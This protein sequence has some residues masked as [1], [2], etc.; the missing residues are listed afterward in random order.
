MILDFY[1]EWCQPC[2]ALAK[3]LES[4]EGIEIQKINIEE[5]TELVEEF[6]IKSV[7]TLIF[8][9]ENGEEKHRMVGNVPLTK[10]KEVCGLTDYQ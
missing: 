7:P 2:K 3:T 8:L 9:N 10:I 4:L 6:K 5:N 1:A